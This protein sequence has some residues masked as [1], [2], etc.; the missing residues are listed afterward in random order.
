MRRRA[1]AVLALPAIL[2]AGCAVRP[3]DFPLPGTRL[4]KPSYQ[5]NVEFDNLASLPVKT[6]VELNGTKVGLVDN[7]KVRPAPG[8]TVPGLPAD[9]QPYYRA[10]AVLDIEDDVQLPAETIVEMT[11][12]TVFGDTYLKLDLPVQG[13][14]RML[15]SGDTIPITQTKPGIQVE[16]YLTAVTSWVNGGNLP[17]IQGFLRN[18]NGAFPDDHGEFQEFLRESTLAVHRIGDSNDELSRVLDNANLIINTVGAATEVWK[19]LFADAPALLAVIQRVI[20]PIFDFANGWRDL[21][22]FINDEASPTKNDRLLRLNTA[23]DTITPLVQAILCSPNQVPRTLA[24]VDAFLQN[25]LV[26]F[27]GARG[28]PSLTISDIRPENPADDQAFHD[29][30][31]PVLHMLGLM[32]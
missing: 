5:I 28:L 2:V 9:K 24:A 14:G 7:V 11:S 18:V 27:L 15:K 30:V 3:M 22:D 1:V 26:P 20:Q 12:H 31:A 21:G 10:T 8:E 32:R 4:G 6:N 29:R 16:D 19:F 13:S 23:I 25:K 17:F